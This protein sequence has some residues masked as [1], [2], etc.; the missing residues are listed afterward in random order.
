M[1]CVSALRSA[2]PPGGAAHTV[3]V[4]TSNP[5]GHGHVWVPI[6]IAEQPDRSWDHIRT[7]SHGDAQRAGA[8][9]VGFRGARE[10]SARA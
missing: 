10:E 8:D 5:S 6:A 3:G 2:V 7:C 9:L 4:V 1:G